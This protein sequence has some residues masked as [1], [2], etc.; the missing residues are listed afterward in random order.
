MVPLDMDV[1]LRKVEWQLTIVYFDDSFIF[2][3][4]PDEHEDHAEQMLTI[5][6]DEGETIKTKKCKF[7]KNHIDY[8]VHVIRPRGFEILT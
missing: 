2:C 4:T 6:Y 3:R 5:L 7:F 1:L 8:L